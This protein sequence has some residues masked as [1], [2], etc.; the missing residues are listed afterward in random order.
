M[1]II[2]AI[3][4]QITRHI[5]TDR[6]ACVSGSVVMDYDFH[7]LQA[8]MVSMFAIPILDDLVEPMTQI[9]VG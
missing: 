9:C 7:L 5:T 1:V 4:T 2:P 3:L 8:Y 6:D